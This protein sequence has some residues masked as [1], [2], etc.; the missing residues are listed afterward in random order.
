MLVRGVDSPPPSAAVVSNP[1]GNAVSLQADT[2]IPS[3]SSTARAPM[4]IAL[5]GP[6]SA[7]KTTLARAIVQEC[8]ER[9]NAAWLSEDF[10]SR[11]LGV[12]WLPSAFLR[13]RVIELASL[14]YSVASWRRYRDFHGT[15]F[16]II[17]EAPGSW[18]YK[19]GLVRLTLRK[20]GIHEMIRRGLQD[21]QVVISDNE[22]TLQGAHHLFV[23]PRGNNDTARV[24]A[25][26]AL[27]PMPDVVVCLRVPDPVVVE[28]TLRRSH[29]R[30]GS[31]SGRAVQEAVR[32]TSEV[33]ELVCGSPALDG[34]L[35]FVYRSQVLDFGDDGA[36]TE[37][38][39]TAAEL[40]SAGIATVRRTREPDAPPER[41]L[42]LSTELATQLLARL[43]ASVAY[44]HWKSNYSLVEGGAEDGDLDLL[45]DPSDLARTL[46]VLAELGFRE[47]M[48]GSGPRTPSVWHYYGCDPSTGAIVHVHLFS[49]VITGES[50]VKS[51]RLPLASMLLENTELHGPVRIPT[52]AAELVLFM[53]RTFIKYGSL[54]DVARLTKDR[55]A[56]R[57]EFRWLESQ[58]SVQDAL[59]LL[60]RH[61][62]RMGEALFL[63]C[64]S[65]LHNDAS[66][67]RRVLLAWRVR[68]RLRVYAVRSRLGRLGAYAGFLSAW[69]WR[70][71]TGRGKGKVWHS[72]GAVIAFVG[73]DAT[74]KS[75]LV[76]ETARWLK[77]ACAVEV[78]HLG[79]PGSSW[80]TLPINIVL[81]A[82][83]VF[84]GGKGRWKPDSGPSSRGERTARIGWASL[85][86]AVRAVVLGFE[87]RRAVRKVWVAATGG[88]LVVCDRYPTSVVDA[89]DGPRLRPDVEVRDT[90][91][92]LYAWLARLEHGL[93]RDLPQPDVL[94]R[95]TVS[96]ETA[97]R[98][99]RDRTKAD[100]HTEEELE[101]RHQSLG[102]WSTRSDRCRDV[103]TEGSLE[104]TLSRLRPVLW[105]LL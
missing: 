1:P 57:A 9:G 22:A 59:A 89:M 66:L 45:V 21:G 105:E 20:T 53:Q 87:R 12:G 102:S 98:R 76:G 54:L 88:G 56:L 23:H 47:A 92:K 63:E 26:A 4:H 41:E 96:L 16:R 71:L 68:D 15:T 103:S 42:A 97:Q 44:T 35:L 94:I 85:I 95:L 30:L 2:V 11:H 8:R 69:A 65:A 6:S 60:E 91:S 32:R 67:L 74:G 38:R 19:A 18:L 78:A 55:E 31:P 75:T 93:Y 81:R 14:L 3:A 83:R 10:A 99:N 104:E 73:P 27:A 70:R 90:R 17:R 43:D 13:R 80:W 40:V 33:F 36:R 64:L 58:C 72:G 49:R 34:R 7:G 5:I 82:A 50:F 100:K 101:G 37:L 25:F 46:A 48:V 61:C 28:R 52:K 62:P 84:R 51:H 24:G 39:S 79:K 29:P 77:S 86:Y